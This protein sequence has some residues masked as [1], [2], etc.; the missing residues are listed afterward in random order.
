ME[1]E[2]E[3]MG[4][5]EKLF[6]RFCRKGEP[7]RSERPRRAR[8]PTRINHPGSEEGYGYWGGR[9]PLER[10]I[11][12]GKGFGRKRRSG[13][14]LREGNPITLREESSEGESPRALEVERDL[15]GLG[16]QEELAERVAKPECEAS[17]E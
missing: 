8:A 14:V 16:G 7:E 3:G 12:A 5:R 15:R 10:R 13:G 2:R 9:K 11:E 1:K 4:K 6:S 17:G